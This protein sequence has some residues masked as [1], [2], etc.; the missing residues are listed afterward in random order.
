[1]AGFILCSLSAVLVATV[2]IVI[3]RGRDKTLPVDETGRFWLLP[4]DD[5]EDPADRAYAD[6]PAWAWIDRS[7]SAA[8]RARFADNWAAEMDV[9]SAKIDRDE[10]WKILDQAY[11]L[12]NEIYHRRVD[13]IKVG[14]SSEYFAWSDEWDAA[15]YAVD[16]ARAGWK[17]AAQQARLEMYILS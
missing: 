4:L 10:R 7:A 13:P 16:A 5:G 12:S 8:D 15:I 2:L 3:E 1:M 14:F 17:W 11:A 6:V 9:S